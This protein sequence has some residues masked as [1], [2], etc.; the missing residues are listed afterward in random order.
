MQR[1]LLLAVLAITLASCG[2]LAAPQPSPS[3][4]PMPTQPVVIYYARIPDGPVPVTARIP[5]SDSVEARIHAR[6]NELAT[7]GSIGPHGA[8]NFLPTVGA[9]L[10][11]VTVSQDL[12]TLDFLVGDGDW[13]LYD[14]AEARAFLQQLVFTAT[15]EPSV[16]RVLVTQ[17]GGIPAVIG[18][19]DVITTYHTALT[20]QQV[21]TRVEAKQGGKP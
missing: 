21:M 7:A 15:D 18:V 14:G 19:K 17:D 2:Q 9:Q 13:V 6:I 4:E 12:A 10:R 20:R 1:S 3:G 8:Y 5:M 16:R 11:H